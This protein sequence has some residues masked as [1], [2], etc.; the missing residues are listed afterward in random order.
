[1][2]VRLAALDLVPVSDLRLARSGSCKRIL[3]VFERPT[4]HRWRRDRRVVRGARGACEELVNGGAPR[5][6]TLALLDEDE[7]HDASEGNDDCAHA[8]STIRG[9]NVQVTRTQN[10]VDPRESLEDFKLAAHTR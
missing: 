5:C 6:A 2:L 10:P 7:S 1:M 8:F 4:A 9:D 3:A